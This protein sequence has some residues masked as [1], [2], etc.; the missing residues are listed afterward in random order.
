VPF[1]FGDPDSSLKNLE[2]LSCGYYMAVLKL[3]LSP[4]LLFVA[5]TTNATLCIIYKS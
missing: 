5:F 2:Y 4:P 1:Q 3:K